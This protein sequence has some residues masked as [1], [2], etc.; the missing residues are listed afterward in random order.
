MK[1]VM[2]FLALGFGVIQLSH[3]QLSADKPG[4]FGVR[5]G[6]SLFNFGG[7]DVSENAY[8]NRVGFHV[9]GYTMLFMTDRLA[10][11]P[12]VY[13]SVKGTQNDDFANS[14]AILNYVDIPVLFRMYP[15]EGFNVF[16][17]PQISFLAS[18]KFEGDFFGNTVSYDSDAIK[19]TDIGLV[20]GVGYNLPKGFNVQ[21]S[22]DYGFTPIFKDSDADVYNRGFKLS[23]GFTF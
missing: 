9:G 13:Y 4:G 14:R 15:G 6:A 20:L 10:L 1:K 23:A 17:G 16:A 7:D 12:G 19:E 22:Y 18:S 3:A 21:A 5:G 8:T 11:E 2:L